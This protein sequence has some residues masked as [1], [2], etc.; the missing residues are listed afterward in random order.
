MQEE[1]RAEAEAAAA[2]K[3]AANELRAKMRATF[4]IF[5]TIMVFT[6]AFG[7]IVSAIEG[8]GL[9]DGMYFAVSP[10]FWWWL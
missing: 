7:G 3:E 5:A 6:L 9:L 2:A 8:W 4:G 10:G 1:G